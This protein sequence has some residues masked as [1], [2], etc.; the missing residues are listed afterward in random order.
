[1]IV[2]PVRTRIF[3]EGENLTSFI[4]EYI[5]RLKERSV[6]VVA[7]KIVAL[8]EERT[9]AVKT[10]KEHDALVK[11]ESDRALAT[12]FVWVTLKDGIVMA[13]AGIDESNVERG[14]VILLPKDSFK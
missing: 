14:G 6:L 7:S 11:K 12:K 3:K 4:S 10:K 9:A 1:M 5:P 13:N 8:A 2:T